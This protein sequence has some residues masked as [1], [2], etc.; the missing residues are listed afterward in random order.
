[1]LVGRQN[2]AVR[3]FWKY[4]QEKELDPAFESYDKQ[5]LENKLCKLY[6]ESRTEYFFLF[7]LTV[8]YLVICVPGII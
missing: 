3:L 5:T 2:Q 4:L 8:Y 1:M 6:A 7:L